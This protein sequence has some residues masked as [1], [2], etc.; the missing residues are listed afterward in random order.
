[1]YGNLDGVIVI[2]KY[3]KFVLN[4]VM[5]MIVDV[6]KLVII[7]F[8]IFCFYKIFIECSLFSYKNIF[9]NV[10]FLL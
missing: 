4:D 7:L 6:C 9:F 3:L 8:L 5:F 2:Y 1:M 10:L